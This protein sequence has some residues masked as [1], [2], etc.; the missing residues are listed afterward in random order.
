M[1][2]IAIIIPCFNEELIVE[3]FYYLLIK[4]LNK[5]N[6][7]FEIIFTNDGST[8]NTYSKIASFNSEYKN[9]N[10]TLLNIPFN[11]GHQSA[12][13]QSFLY[14]NEFNFDNI[15]IMDSDGEDDPDKISDILK[16]NNF[17]LVQV[18]R[19]K[20]REH[21]FFKI[22]YKFYKLIYFMILGKKINF[23][24]FCLIS[25]RLLLASLHKDFDHLGSFLDNQKCLKANITI[26][27]KKRLG[28]ASKMNFK[29][30]FVHSINSFLQ[31]PESLLFFQLKVASISVLLFIIISTVIFYKKYILEVAI[32]GWSSLMTSSFLILM[33]LYLG[34]FINGYLTNKSTSNI[35]LTRP[36]LFKINI[37]YKN[38]N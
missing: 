19:G 29:S 38:W 31:N 20:R 10:L 15:L 24:N 3:D 14:V 26:D 9:L 2:K 30:L 7:F 27:R 28:G 32:P 22:M 23:G 21:L 36:R 35:F 1:K 37:I 5:L 17:D 11:I 6:F 33:F 12:I 18:V 4:N 13:Y 8:D 25:E 16:L 34:L